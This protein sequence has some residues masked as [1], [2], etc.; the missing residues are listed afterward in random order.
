MCDQDLSKKRG[1]I[2]MW[3]KFHYKMKTS[4]EE[5][6]LYTEA[7]EILLALFSVYRFSNLNIN[8]TFGVEMVLLV[9]FC[10]VSAKHV[11]IVAFD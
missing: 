9:A 5:L 7:Q 4:P 8:D 3:K 1:P 10:Q 11:A 2:F 6:M